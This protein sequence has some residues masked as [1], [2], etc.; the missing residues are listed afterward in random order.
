MKAGLGPEPGVAAWVRVLENLAAWPPDAVLLIKALGT[1]LAP[2]R[3]ARQPARYLQDG[4]AAAFTN[5]QTA[6]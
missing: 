1:C 5:V 2:L 6:S 4:G 3:R